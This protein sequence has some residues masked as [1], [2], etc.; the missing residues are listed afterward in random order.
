MNILACIFCFLAG[1]G[2]GFLVTVLMVAAAEER[3]K[4]DG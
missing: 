2:V 4:E 3:R 1:G